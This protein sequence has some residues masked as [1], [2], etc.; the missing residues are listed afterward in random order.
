MVVVVVGLLGGVA[1]RL[2]GGQL[3]G[4]RVQNAA[5]Q[6]AGDLSRTSVEALRR[7]RSL[8]ITRNGATGYT[9]DSIGAR[10]L[11]DGVAFVTNQ[12]ASSVRFASIG[13][14]TTAGAFVLSKSSRQQ[15]VRLTS[16]G[17]VV[18]E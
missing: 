10:T 3:D 18:I 2:L 11:P 9:I 14:P 8:S 15:T 13:P 6:L 7:N 16:A 5:R 1:A 4:Q 12:S 17:R